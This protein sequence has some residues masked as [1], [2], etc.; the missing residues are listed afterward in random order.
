[1]QAQNPKSAYFALWSRLEGF[2]PE[3]LGRL[4]EQRKAVR[5]VLQRSTLHLA[6]ARDC[7]RLSPTLA[8]VLERNFHVGSPFGRRVRGVDLAKLVAAGRVLVEERPRTLSELRQLLGADFPDYDPTSLAYAVHNLLPLV[9]VTPRGVWG[10]SGQ[11]SWTTLE[12][13]V[14]KPLGRSLSTE[15]L[16]QRY[17]AAF[18]PASA[19]D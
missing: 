16:F 8:G 6:T 12:S 13:W 19:R 14:G 10:R 7:L 3:L 18:G 2:R 17:L 9:Q 11:P 1:M 4:L 5:A 15:A